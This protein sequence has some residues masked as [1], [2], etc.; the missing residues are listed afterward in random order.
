MKQQQLLAKYRI[1]YVCIVT[2]MSVVP[3]KAIGKQGL[4]TSAQGL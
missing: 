3:Q 1:V 2:R 4:V